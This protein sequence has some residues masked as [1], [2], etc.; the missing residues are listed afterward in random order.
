MQADS[1]L[2]F[3]QIDT[4][5]L[6]VGGQGGGGGVWVWYKVLR[7]KIYTWLSGMFFFRILLQLK[8]KTKAEIQAF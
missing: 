7:P 5:F 1:C 4:L 6:S 2:N 3:E 8:I